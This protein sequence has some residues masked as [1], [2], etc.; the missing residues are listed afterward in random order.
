MEE[1]KNLITVN[2]DGHDLEV[3]LGTNMVEAAAMLSKEIPH[4]CYHP[5]LSIA[6]N[7]RMCL[8]ELG[9]PGRDRATG[10]AMLNEDGTPKIMWMP[11]PAIGCGTKAAP[12]MHI[13]TD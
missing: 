12:G 13:K 9:M 2:I 11:G 1:K 7:C 3:P 10:E 4:Y 8:V 5:K 6:G